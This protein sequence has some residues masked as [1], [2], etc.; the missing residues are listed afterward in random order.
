MV[1]EWMTIGPGKRD[2]HFEVELGFVLEGRMQR[3]S[4]THCLELQAGDIWC[5]GIWEPHSAYVRKS[6]LR[7][8]IL[9][10]YPPYLANLSLPEQPDLNW[11]APFT[12]HPERRPQGAIL[13]SDTF[14]EITSRLSSAQCAVTLHL[15][16]LQALWQIISR[17]KCQAPYRITSSDI[18]RLETALKLVFDNPRLVTIGEAASACHMSRNG[19]NLFFQRVM[20]VT[21]AQFALHHRLSQAASDLVETDDPIKQI[22]DRWGFTD[23][24][25]FH[26]CFRAIFKALPSDYRR[27][28]Y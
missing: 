16:A 18:G 12:D 21:F 19:F 23:A 2:M 5:N 20:G 15:D 9:H 14:Q 22:A 4:S 7:L 10:L 3:E 13:S 28:D 6:P 27:G 17:W 8:A 25:H 11:L 1:D 26:R 24:S